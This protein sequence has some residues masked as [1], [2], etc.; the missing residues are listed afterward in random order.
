MKLKAKKIIL[1][2][3]DFAMEQIFFFEGEFSF[4]D[5]G[6]H[7]KVKSQDKKIIQFKLILI[8]KNKKNISI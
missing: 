3:C 1:F 6:G 4:Y 7:S 8:S 5:T 2:C